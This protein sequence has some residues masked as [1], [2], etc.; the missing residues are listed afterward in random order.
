MSELEKLVMALDALAAEASPRPWR[1]THPNR[2]VIDM[3]NP[4]RAPFAVCHSD[5]GSGRE[6]AAFMLAL[7]EAWPTIRSALGHSSI[8]TPGKSKP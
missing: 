2:V 8:S 3:G 7:V 5:D 4:P 6:N 1:I